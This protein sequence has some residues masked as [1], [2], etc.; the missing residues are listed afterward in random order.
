MLSFIKGFGTS[1]W[2]ADRK[3]IHAELDNPG[4]GWY[5]IYT[6]FPGEQAF[7]EPV[8]YPGET[9]ALVLMNVGAYRERDLDLDVLSEMDHILSCFEKLGLEMI[10]RICY[11]TEGKGMVR[12]P[13]L[14]S[15]VK[16]HVIQIAPVLKKHAQHIF[17]WQG[18]LI[19]NWGEMHGSKFLTPKFLR[20]LTEIFLRETEHQ[21]RI[22]FRK[23]VQYRMAFPENDSAEG[24]GFFNDGIFGSDS[25]LGTFGPATAGRGAWQEPWGTEEELGFMA[26]FVRNVPYGGEVVMP[27]QENSFEE[28]TRTL[29]DL[30]V[31]YLNSTH[32]AVLLEQWAKKSCG[33]M[34]IRDYVGE[35][36]GYRFLVKRVKGKLGRTLE[37]SIEIE[38]AGFANLCDDAEVRIL[39]G[40]GKAE[41]ILGS[42]T[43]N[44]RDVSGGETAAFKGSFAAPTLQGAGKNLA[45]S[46]YAKIVR[47]RDGRV[48]LFAQESE[49][50][51][52]LLGSF[53]KG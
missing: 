20:E 7:E 10:L 41:T 35:R 1:F 2:E 50:G 32:D 37:M 49:E 26:P 46:L 47:K 5:R 6:Y 38:N 28:I 34:S 27:P 11:D 36:L 45:F 15:Q 9:L 13:S 29:R 53:R 48:I 30:K 16:N 8:R 17:V 14:F 25:H 23:P 22:C 12:E 43:G 31:T 21:I 51:C 19:G 18:L 44:L 33:E 24:I 40:D 4:R 3:E 39:W 42:L 52:L